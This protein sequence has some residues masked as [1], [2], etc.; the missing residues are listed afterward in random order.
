MTNDNCEYKDCWSRIPNFRPGA[1]LTAE[2]LN[3]SQADSIRRDRLVNIAMHG[4]GVAYGY[5]VETDDEGRMIVRDGCIKVSC[6]LAFDRYGRMLFWGGGY[7]KMEDIIGH[8]P[9]CKGP[10]TLSVHYAEKSD[11]GGA[12]DPCHEGTDWVKRCVVFTLRKGCSPHDHCAPD[13]PVDECMTR[14][15]WICTRNGFAQG[16][17]LMDK[18]LDNA[19]VDPPPLVA[20]D[21]GRVAYDPDA[22]IPLSCVEICDLDQDQ[23]QDREGCK[24]RYGFCPC[25][26]VDNCNLRPVAYRNRL[27]HELI[28]L[29]DL[30]LAK[31]RDYSWAEWEL[32]E[33]SDDNRVPFSEFGQRVRACHMYPVDPRAG[34]SLMFTRPVQRRT[35]HP[36]SI[37]M[38]IFILESRA[39]YWEPWRISTRIRHLD[40]NGRILDENS[41]GECAWGAM[42]CPEEDWI[43]YEI[44]DP[45]STILDC[46]N[47]GRLARVEI[48]VRGQ[49]VRDCCGL[50]IDA[51][52]PDIDRHDPCANR[53][54]QERA[55]D[56]FLSVF[57]VGRN[58]PD[59]CRDDDDKS[60]DPD[61]NGQ[62]DE[63][64]VEGDDD[65]GKLS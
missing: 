29:D 27:L 10:F 31:I 40:E 3:A 59:E 63:Y 16:D 11:Q 9:G 19:C 60:V 48:T 47:Q 13:I 38:D 50:M 28:N 52:P 54:G 33:W 23:D 2:Q 41:P 22:G 55:G 58:Y 49:I 34:F 8:K 1:R 42:I 36:M 46:A 35:L 6:G 65:M 12:F 51:R 15:E 14:R 44:D 7:L 17:V 30:P 21:C 37:I 62:S 61:D 32:R 4:V 5:R 39:N 57:R 26:R 64:P 18:A 56:D 53:A 20:S 24:P 45:K 43:K 25:G